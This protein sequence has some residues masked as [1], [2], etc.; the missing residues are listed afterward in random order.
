M[1]AQIPSMTPG[2]LQ[3]F[4]RSEILDPQGHAD[5]REALR[6]E[7]RAATR[8]YIQR[9]TARRDAALAAQRRERAPGQPDAEA[10]PLP[11]GDA[12]SPMRQT[13][14][15]DDTRET[16]VDEG[17]AVQKY[18]TTPTPETMRGTGI[19]SAAA[20]GAVEGAQELSETFRMGQPTPE[21]GQPILAGE[22]RE[23]GLGSLQSFIEDASPDE[24]T[25]EERR[26]WVDAIGLQ[27]PQ[28][29]IAETVA[30]ISQFATGMALTAPAGGPVGRVAGSLAFKGAKAAFGAKRAEKAAQ[31]AKV[32]T[33][34]GG[35]MATGAMADAFAFD[36]D[37]HSGLLGQLVDGNP[38][39]QDILQEMM[40]A[41]D[42]NAQEFAARTQMAVE[43]AF[44]GGA[45]GVGMK[46]GGLVF[47]RMVG[48]VQVRQQGTELGGADP[49]TQANLRK[50]ADV[51]AAQGADKVAKEIEATTLPPYPQIGETAEPPRL[52]EQH[53]QELAE[54]KI[55]I[56]PEQARNPDYVGRKRKE[57]RELRQEVGEDEIALDA[58]GEDD[59]L[60]GLI[61]EKR[62]EIKA[63]QDHLGPFAEGPED[64]ADVQRMVDTGTDVIET[65]AQAEAR[66]A[67]AKAAEERK[68]AEDDARIQKQ[69]EEVRARSPDAKP[70]DGA[71]PDAKPGEAAE[72]PVK[73]RREPPAPSDIVRADFKDLFGVEDDLLRVFRP[74]EN[75]ALSEMQ[76]DIEVIAS[77]KGTFPNAT[78]RLN[79]EAQARMAQW[80]M[81]RRT[82]TLRALGRSLTPW[83][84]D[85]AL[86]TYA[87]A[88]RRLVDAYSYLEARPA[89]V[90]RQAALVE[91]TDAYMK[92][93]RDIEPEGAAA[94][95]V[96][97]VA[98]EDLAE[99]I[100]GLREQSISPYFNPFRQDAVDGMTS[101]RVRTPQEVRAEK[102][103][104]VGPTKEDAF[105]SAQHTASLEPVQ[106]PGDVAARV[107]GYD[108]AAAA[109][110]P[111]DVWFGKLDA[112]DDFDMIESEV[113]VARGIPIRTKRDT[114]RLDEAIAKRD[115][116]REKMNEVGDRTGTSREGYAERE[117]AREAYFAAAKEAEVVRDASRGRMGDTQW[118][119][120]QAQA[121]GAIF[122]I[123]GVRGYGMRAGR[124]TGDQRIGL[125]GKPHRLT[126]G[127]NI[128]H[129]VQL[130]TLDAMA[131]TIQRTATAASAKG[132]TASMRADAASS[133]HKLAAYVERMYG[134]DGRADAMLEAARLPRDIEGM[135][136]GIPRR[137]KGHELISRSGGSQ[138]LDA[139]LA[140]IGAA[141]DT[142]TVLRILGNWTEASQGG[143]FGGS[144]GAGFRQQQAVWLAYTSGLLS[145]PA[146]WMR[147]TG[148]SLMFGAQRGGAEKFISRM[149][150]E[151]VVRGGKM[152][153]KEIAAS[154][155]GIWQGAM[156]GVRLA[157]LMARQ[158]LDLIGKDAAAKQIHENQW[159]AIIRDMR[160]ATRTDVDE[161]VQLHGL[162]RG[163]TDW[164]SRK[165]TSAEML[166]KGLSTALNLAF[167]LGGKATMYGDALTRTI[168]LR[169]NLHARA[170]RDGYG[171]G[172][173]K[174]QAD[175]Y[176]ENLSKDK[177]AYR[178]AMDSA[179]TNAFLKE[180]Q[181][182]PTQVMLE[183][184]AKHPWLAAI[185]PFVNSPS[186]IMQEGIRR[187][188]VLGS[189]YDNWLAR[190]QGRVLSDQ[191][192]S[193]AFARQ[194]LFMGIAGVGGMAV[195]NGNLTGGMA[196]RPETRRAMLKTGWRPWS[197]KVGDEYHS[198]E[199]ILGP[200]ALPIMWGGTVV[201]LMSSVSS[202]EE[203]DEAFSVIDAGMRLFADPI[204]SMTWITGAK[205]GFNVLGDLMR[206]DTG[207]AINQLQ[208]S[209]VELGTNI[210]TPSSSLMKAWEKARLGGSPATAFGEGM[211]G[212]DETMREAAF[213]ALGEIIQ[214]AEDLTLGNLGLA[215]GAYP[216]IDLFGN[217]NPYGNLLPSQTAIDEAGFGHVPTTM[218]SPAGRT[219][220]AN[221]AIASEAVRLAWNP[222]WPPSMTRVITNP[223]AGADGDAYWEIGKE[224]HHD[225]TKKVSKRFWT[226]A[227][228]GMKYNVYKEMTPSKKRTQLSAWLSSAK[229]EAWN[230]LAGSEKW[231]DEIAR[232]DDEAMERGSIRALKARQGELDRQASDLEA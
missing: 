142:Q 48:Q 149:H 46:V 5:R 81:E 182:L 13:T 118:E 170:A 125:L 203:Y 112:A 229:K 39:L 166:G 214:R 88:E 222:R 3:A 107:V 224:L 207:R 15:K 225:W 36:P 148:G 53:M 174:E 10:F 134:R 114:T 164:L 11:E 126:T 104:S 200:M 177:K 137:V 217:G 27:Q 139:T 108:Q 37:E 120:E 117:A 94:L 184:K 129:R 226:L 213:E 110:D 54:G 102:P 191:D 131:S 111:I 180:S 155:S 49:A 80:R 212:E 172:W 169:A 204:L 28:G 82:A 210:M 43:G 14:P 153:T 216:K 178:E 96:A 4:N 146:T 84:D 58:V 163:M 157:T 23:M 2:E 93:V 162:P 168:A 205:Q 70:V 106:L 135:E 66:T 78:A 77:G 33:G 209:G 124:L 68:I 158:D 116:A 132:A 206:D 6:Q 44:I 115:A 192:K 140:A 72:A 26:R 21:A 202:E 75:R 195:Y 38:E 186:Q 147:N 71:K 56:T 194:A 128:D 35:F 133:L 31:A 227:N 98:K 86:D 152:A 42:P 201:E 7:D 67:R 187:V 218:I 232:N 179:E 32:A 62:I 231:R 45:V 51:A 24:E 99:W 34:G 69:I 165:G 60:E 9:R 30:T 55:R 130:H 160:A 208:R 59:V 230:E 219:F 145:R 113:A 97:N 138:V 143:V 188:P 22:G 103:A 150:S 173:T 190:K 20:Y 156:E 198:I 215:E 17:V 101:R 220:D 185:T 119:A 40:L 52:S 193:D 221:N 121:K 109:S 29:A 1:P 181:D 87:T 228:E 159:E 90:D 122:D 105:T 79:A 64:A 100:K 73:P 12:P 85:T 89:A 95:N 57:L 136:Q 161:S 144:R 211:A 151:G 141:P 175:E 176:V 74:E 61:R 197:I 41:P 183:L 223:G 25:P 154:F 167:S 127:E 19:G 199:G 83:M 91:A 76:K 196:G 18:G 171:Q 50:E 92:T 123:T 16:A 47:K 8:Q 65:P 63:R 189:K